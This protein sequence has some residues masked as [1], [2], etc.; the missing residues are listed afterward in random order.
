MGGWKDGTYFSVNVSERSLVDEKAEAICLATRF[1]SLSSNKLHYHSTQE[2]KTD[3]I[4][5]GG[6]CIRT[7]SAALNFLQ[8]YNIRGYS[9]NPKQGKQS[10]IFNEEIIFATD[11]EKESGGGGGG[12]KR[13]LAWRGACPYKK[14]YSW[15]ECPFIPLSL[16]KGK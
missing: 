5:G 7:I 1:I 8:H 2:L 10:P 15:K 11:A 14:K 6:K 16:N 13:R 4:K 12:V 9:N 3:I